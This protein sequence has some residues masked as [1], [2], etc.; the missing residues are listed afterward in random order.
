MRETGELARRGADPRPAEAPD[1]V[2]GGLRTF[3]QRLTSIEQVVTEMHQ[4]LQHQNVEKDW[5]TATELAQAMNVT[6]YTV[7]E[8][9]C[10]QGRIAAEKDPDTGKWRIPGD[11]FRRLVRGGGLKTARS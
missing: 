7:Q 10:N 6:Q 8:R 3:G 11:E 5:Y 4:M 1:A 2:L 9:W